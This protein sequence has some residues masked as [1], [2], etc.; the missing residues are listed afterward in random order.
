[1]QVSSKS[2]CCYCANTTAQFPSASPCHFY[3]FGLPSSI[4]ETLSCLRRCGRRFGSTIRYCVDYQSSLEIEV[5]SQNLAT[6]RVAETSE[7]VM[8]LQVQ[9]SLKESSLPHTCSLNNILDKHIPISCID[10]TTLSTTSLS[11]CLAYTNYFVIF[12]NLC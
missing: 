12:L 10:I 1:M 9:L 4:K 5:T 8:I 6:E 3:A 2:Y 11:M 7:V